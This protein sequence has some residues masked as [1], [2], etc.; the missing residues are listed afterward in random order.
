MF[1]ENCGK[2]I[3]DNAVFCNYCG[4]KVRRDKLT[5]KTDR[6]PKEPNVENS[7]EEDGLHEENSEHNRDESFL[8][9]I[10]Q[11]HVLK[12]IYYQIKELH[13]TMLLYFAAIIY[14][15]YEVMLISSECESS[16]DPS[17]SIGSCIIVKSCN[18]SFFL[19]WCRSENAACFHGSKKN[20]AV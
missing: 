12:F 2:K 1:C 10:N 14:V 8:K 16:Y 4:A 3:D 18:M 9:N 17:V 15:T 19:E 20:R 6:N 7:I 5:S 13:F 11:F